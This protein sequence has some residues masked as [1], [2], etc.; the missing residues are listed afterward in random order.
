MIGGLV[1][2]LAGHLIETAKLKAYAIAFYAGA[3]ASLLI[4]LV[5]ALVG[6]RHWIAVT[7]LSQYPDLW[8]ALG[9]VVI[10][11]L[12]IG[13]GVYWQKQKPKTNPAMDIALLAGPS[14]ARIAFRNLSPRVV[15]VG[16]VLIVGLFVGR[17][18][19]SA[20][21]AARP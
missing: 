5:F 19:T 7:Y 16:V 17:R 10:T 14:A 13:I 11:G 6:L 9:F 2:V 18:M 1:T 3:G 12:L 20:R 4:A 21:R 15:A 8:I